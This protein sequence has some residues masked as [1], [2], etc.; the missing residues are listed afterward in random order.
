MIKKI[1]FLIFI[2]YSTVFATDILNNFKK[3]E[4]LIN[5]IHENNTKDFEKLLLNT[6]PNIYNIYTPTLLK[7]CVV[8]GKNIRFVKLLVANSINID[9]KSGL[10][11]TTATHDAI[12]KGNYEVSNYLIRK[13][14]NIDIKDSNGQTLLHFAVKYSANEIIKLLLNA[15]INKHIKDKFGNTAYDLSKK[16]LAIDII[17]TNKL[18]NKIDKKNKSKINESLNRNKIQN[19]LESSKIIN[20]LKSSKIINRLKSLKRTNIYDKQYIKDN[21][22]IG[23]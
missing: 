21:I 2:S 17:L 3:Y 18:K 10:A 12:E 7:Q 23:K 20:K 6:N 14:K 9:F 5:Y 19:K 4:M 15:G 11:N 13:L 16:N 1:I 22:Y 8:K